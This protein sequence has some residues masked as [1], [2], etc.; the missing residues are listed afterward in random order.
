MSALTNHPAPMTPVLMPHVRVE[1]GQDAGLVVTVDREPYDIP[2]DWSEQGRQAVPRIVEEITTR[3][4]TPIRI[5]VVDAGSTFT[6]IVTP[7]DR[8]IEKPSRGATTASEAS[9]PLM[10][11]VAGGGFSPDEPVAIAVVV[12]HW[13][14]D[15]NGVARLRLPQALLAARPGLVVLLGQ[16]SGAV[17]VSGGTP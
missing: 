9:T 4:A 15:A 6:D 11:D 17:A 3:L 13:C 10:C 2:A 8:S 1:V 5:E 12:A 16:T 14:A 7:H